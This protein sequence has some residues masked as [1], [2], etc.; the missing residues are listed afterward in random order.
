MAKEKRKGSHP[1]RDGKTIG[2]TLRVPMALLTV[3]D[4]IAVRANIIDLK[5]GGA[6]GVTAQEVMR[7]RLASLPLAM[8]IGKGTA[9][10]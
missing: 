3:Y 5:R 6:G 7:H 2:I 1:S 4:N 8:V 9:D 10:E